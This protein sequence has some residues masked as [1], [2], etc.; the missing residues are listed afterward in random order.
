[1]VLNKACKKYLLEVGPKLSVS[2]SDVA[3][4]LRFFLI[5]IPLDVNECAS[6]CRDCEKIRIYSYWICRR[7]KA[8]ECNGWLKQ[9]SDRRVEIVALYI[10]EY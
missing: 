7:S 10:A 9:I 2:A 3:V 8:N 4:F 5:F 1:L 6:L